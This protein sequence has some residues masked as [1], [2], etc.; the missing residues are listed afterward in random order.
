MISTKSGNVLTDDANLT[1]LEEKRPLAELIN[2]SRSTP[3]SLNND[4]KWN[5]IEMSS[6]RIACF[7]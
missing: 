7:T 6:I 3:P 1:T 2:T 4:L 5:I